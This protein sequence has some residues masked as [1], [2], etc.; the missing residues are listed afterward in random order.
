MIPTSGSSNR[1]RAIR[2]SAERPRIPNASRSPRTRRT[3]PS[4]FGLEH[5][6]GVDGQLR[7]FC[8]VGALRGEEFVDLLGG[9][10]QLRHA[11][12]AGVGDGEFGAVL[13]GEQAD[14]G[15]L[16][17]Q[18]QVLGHD[19]HVV[20]LRLKVSGHCQDPRVVV[21][22]PVTRGKHPRV[23]VVEFDSEGPAQ[24]PD[25]DRRVEPPIPDAVLVEEAQC[26]PG[27]VTEFRMV[28]LGLQLGDHDDGKHDLVLVE[29]NHGHGVGQQDAG[30]D[31]VC[32]PVV[33]TALRTGHHGWTNPLG[34]GR[35]AT[36]SP[37]N[38]PGSDHVARAVRRPSEMSVRGTPASASRSARSSVCKGPP[39]RTAPC[40]PLVPDA[41]V[42]RR[43]GRDIPSKNRCHSLAYDGAYGTLYNKTV[44]S[45]LTGA[46]KK[47]SCGAVIPGAH[48]TNAPEGSSLEQVPATEPEA[49]RTVRLGHSCR[50][51][52]PASREPPATPDAHSPKRC[53]V[54]G[55]GS[56][57]R[58]CTCPWNGDRRP[59]GTGSSALRQCAGTASSTGTRHPPASRQRR[60]RSASA[61][62]GRSRVPQAP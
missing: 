3:R 26:L 52:A 54:Q 36:A 56:P 4:A 43:L 50:P 23:G 32:A 39:G 7:R 41:H 38:G 24:L 34:R 14:G 42:R 53:S 27:E 6:S 45:P 57:R 48:H 17:P 18:G 21:A 33:R 1:S 31:D 13:L 46:G 2:C 25:R 29:A 16:D 62:R 60:E 44:K 22:Q 51:V 30:V 8:H 5:Q 15:S 9:D 40:R 19:R 55:T 61:R 10:G 11:R 35:G 12:P 20:S 28:P 58:W 47:R 59:S 49:F 37:G